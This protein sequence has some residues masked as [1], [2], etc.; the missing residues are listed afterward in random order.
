MRRARTTAQIIK[1]DIAL[2]IEIVR[3]VQS[4]DETKAPDK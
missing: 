3:D 4:I 2:E 1:K